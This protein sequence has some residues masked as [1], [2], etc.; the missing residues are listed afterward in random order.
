MR[1]LLSAV[2]LLALTSPLALV[3]PNATAAPPATPTISPEPEQVVQRTDG[4]PITPVVGLVRTPRS[5]PDA[6]RVVREAL[7]RAGV[8]TV[9][10]TDGSDPGTPTT[11]WLGR[12]TSVLSGLH[13][14]DSTGLPAEGYVLAAGRD[15]KHRAQIVL[16]GVD[17]DGTF[18]AAQ[19]LSQLVR[20]NWMPGVAV[21]DWP[22]MRY[23]G[24]IEGFY[25][26]PWSQA[27][28]LDHLDY[29]GAHRM[30]TYEYAPKDDPYHREQWRDPYPADKLAQLG[31]LVTRARQNKVDFTF[32]LSPGLSICYTSDTDFQALI[33]KFEALYELGARSFNVPLDDIDYNSWHCDADRVKY[34]TGGEAAGRAQSDLLNRVQ[35][36]W[37]E[38]KPDVAPLQMVPTEYYNVSETPYK[39]VLREQ[40]DAAVVVHWTGIGVVP[41]AITAAQAAQAKAV[42]GH[43]ILIWDNYPVNDYAAGRLLLA[44]YTGREP[45]IA[46]DVVGVISNPMNQAAVSKIALYSF[47]EF[48]WN[49]A[50][51]DATAVWLRA[52]GERSGG[53]RRTADALK[54]FA[55]LNT[56][57]GTLH[58]ESAPVF[59]A[60]VNE[61]WQRW[62]GGQRAQA[63]ALLRPRVNAIVAAPGT[64]RRGVVD[65]AFTAQAESWLKATEL[66]GQA[67]SRALDLLT[68]LEAGNGAAAW[69]ARQQMSA[70]VTQAKAIRD[71]RA[72]HD[73]TYPRIGE[74]VVDELIAETGR[75]HDRWLGVTPG[76]SATTNLGTYQEN[77]P[78][79]MVDGDENTFYWSDGS[80]GPDSEVRVDLGSAVQI[81]AIAVLM[82][83][84][85]SPDDYIHSGALE[86]S[87]DGTQWSELTRA[88][89]AEV[90]FTAPAGTLARYVRYR[91]L[92]ASDFWLVVR[93]FSVATVGGE[94]TTLTVSGTPAPAAGSSYQRAVDGDVASAYVPAAAPNVGDALV[95]TL[96]APRAL[97]RL[98]VL[99]SSVGSADV[100]V[101]VDGVWKRVGSVSS[102]YAEVP[103]GDV[104]AEAV[105]LVWKGGAPS[106]A[107]LI[108]LWTDTPLVALRT[109]ADR[110]DVVRGTPASV[111]IDVSAGPRADVSGSLRIS[112][113]T[114]WALEAPHKLTVKRGFTQSVTVKLTPP[115]DAALAD[116][117]IPIAL[118]STTAVLRLAVRPRT[119]ATNIALHH[120]VVASSIEPGTTFTADLAVDGD[121]A[122]RWAS[123][124]DD[125][126]WLQV[127][128]GSP[129]HLGKLVLRWEAAYGSAYKIEVSDD[130]TTWT[131]A[132]DVT[133]GDGGTDTL[134]L[135]ATGRYVRLQGVH[136]ATPYG[137]SL[138]E[139]EVFPA[140]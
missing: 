29:L 120:P 95:A 64:I 73:G 55:D 10:T 30:N 26:T 46:D 111:V 84:A 103:V 14:Q 116:V 128:L 125:A 114:G 53:D 134:W 121:P 110:V 119:S 96:S 97:S 59:G 132:A 117:D 9:R 21:R 62:R 86:Y 65:P 113:P 83:K 13:V 130:A 16:D 52:I 82:G 100:E 49:P 129:T 75:V 107:E 91:S 79:R 108:P 131:T 17:S 43:D 104:L 28:R 68:A 112:S 70:L 106:V 90:R 18:Y 118:G 77:V 11:I 60:A 23:R 122:T 51:Y 67:M 15:R 12:T 63:I 99:Q 135:D 85:S 3:A 78:A 94:N 22:T 25:G 33:A 36:E 20:R 61:F 71:S 58:P 8:K 88:T 66:W 115:A 40:L 48:G 137:Y 136:R 92:T 19:S 37:I 5:D 74:R 50:R 1:L 41:Q 24:S 140:A 2:S 57:D 54:V 93:E 47:A 89:S 76:K 127:D 31:E 38:S 102:A 6:E 32:A 126:S 138:Y 72:P 98:T 105:R 4:F 101:Q 124:Y 44:P 7:T 123:G 109:S 87:V 34:G 35:R 69:T 42:F 133:T 81:G 139:A 27:E 80:P 39:K 56:Y 45:G